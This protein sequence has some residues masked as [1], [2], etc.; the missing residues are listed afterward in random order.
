MTTATS[1]RATTACSS[2]RSAA[3]SPGLRSPRPARTAPRRSRL[4]RGRENE[5]R[6][7]GAGD[8]AR[9]L[10]DAL[11]LAYC[12]QPFVDA[13]FN[14]QLADERRLAGWQSGLLWAD[15]QP[16]PSSGPVRDVIAAIRKNALTCA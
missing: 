10:I 8:Q 7:L 5:S 3:R 1:A 14:F 16:K 12:S 9:Q 2:T 6:P 4:Y 11:K 15:W 13:F